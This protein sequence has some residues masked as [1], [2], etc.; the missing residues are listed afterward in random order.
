MQ[1]RF[2]EL[3]FHGYER[4]REQGLTQW[5]YTDEAVGCYPAV[6]NTL[7]TAYVVIPPS[8]VKQGLL[9]DPYVMSDEAKVKLSL[10]GED[11]V[12]S[13]LKAATDAAMSRVAVKWYTEN[14]GKAGT[15]KPIHTFKVGQKVKAW[16]PSK[17][18]GEAQGS[19]ESGIVSRVDGNRVVVSFPESGGSA[20]IL[21]RQAA[22]PLTR[23]DRPRHRH[24]LNPAHRPASR[25]TYIL[26]EGATA[27]VPEEP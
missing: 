3:D 27:I 5:E 21:S 17:V 6:E 7:S 24:E 15:Q 8:Y 4:L 11:E 1:G 14:K 19:M 18:R 2:A 9:A 12:N 13:F 20:Y 16:R 23:Q 25:E 10:A 26:T 22:N